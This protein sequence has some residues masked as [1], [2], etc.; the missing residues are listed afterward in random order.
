MMHR[1]SEF[2]LMKALGAMTRQ[3]VVKPWG[4]EII[5][6][7]DESL[8]IKYITVTDG[9]RTSLQHHNEGKEVI[10]ILDGTG[11]IVDENGN[12]YEGVDPTLRP[13]MPI[14]MAPGKIHR[15]VGPITLLEF[16]TA[17]PD[18]IVRRADRSLT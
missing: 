2:Q 15:T 9:N 16:T 3:T 10:I 12:S 17:S 4:R 7:P 5:Y 8:Q 13:S 1:V 6:R 18:D 11:T 14:F